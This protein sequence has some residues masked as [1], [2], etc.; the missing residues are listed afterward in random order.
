MDSSILRGSDGECCWV[1]TPDGWWVEVDGLDPRAM[2]MYLLARKARWVSMMFSPLADGA[3]RLTY[4][5]DVA[6]RSLNIVTTVAGRCVGS[7]ADL[8]PAATATE[9]ELHERFAIEFAPV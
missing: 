6:G 2:T 4:R 8:L 7:V 9:R 1:E 5:W 3:S